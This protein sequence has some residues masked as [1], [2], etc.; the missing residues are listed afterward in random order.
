MEIATPAGFWRVEVDDIFWAGYFFDL[1]TFVLDLYMFFGPG[2]ILFWTWGHEIYVEDLRLCV[3]WTEI[4]EN[5]SGPGWICVG[6]CFHRDSI[7][8]CAHIGLDVFRTL[9]PQGASWWSSILW[10]GSLL[11]AR[12]NDLRR[13]PGIG[14]GWVSTRFGRKG[15]RWPLS[16]SIWL[17]HCL[18]WLCK[19]KKSPRHFSS[20]E[21]QSHW[22]DTSSAVNSTCTTASIYYMITYKMSSSSATSTER[23]APRRGG[24]ETAATFNKMRRLEVLMKSSSG[25]HTERVLSRV[26]NISTFFNEANRKWQKFFWCLNPS[27]NMKTTDKKEERCRSDHVKNADVSLTLPTPH[28]PPLTCP[29]SMMYEHAHER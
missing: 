27:D 28:L 6:P 11:V 7:V 5:F 25:H 10:T 16:K 8:L 2:R 20:W 13:G 29:A 14:K 22:C 9:A 26:S 4:G 24:S 1:S 21:V 19:R 17:C 23:Y 18:C 12:V 3:S 15:L